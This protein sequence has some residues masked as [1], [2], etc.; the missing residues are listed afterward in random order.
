MDALRLVA[1]CGR[2]LAS[3]DRSDHTAGRAA[4]TDHG[5]EERDQADRERHD[6]REQQRDAPDAGR[7]EG[8]LAAVTDALSQLET[9][10]RFYEPAL[11]RLR[12]ELLDEL[13]PDARDD[14]EAVSTGSSTKSE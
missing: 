14:A 4:S 7:R 8:A 1:C 10:G 11:H 13:H 3:Q 6:E 12:G 2:V 9:S 5:D